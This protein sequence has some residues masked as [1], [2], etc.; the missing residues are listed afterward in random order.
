M[1][2]GNSEGH[3]E[4]NNLKSLKLHLCEFRQVKH[5]VLCSVMKVVDFYL[6]NVVSLSCSETKERNLFGNLVLGTTLPLKQ[7][8]EGQD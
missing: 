1:L 7:N 8:D 2:W 4:K 6:C 3:S 5:Y